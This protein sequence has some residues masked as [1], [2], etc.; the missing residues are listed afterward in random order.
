MRKDLGGPCTEGNGDD[1]RGLLLSH[2]G[3]VS[4]RVD[5]KTRRDEINVLRSSCLND[6]WRVPVSA[7]TSGKD[8]SRL[9]VRAGTPWTHTGHVPCT[10]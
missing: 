7:S 3:R 6:E 2:R 1:T 9:R 5:R 4:R 10:R 8:W